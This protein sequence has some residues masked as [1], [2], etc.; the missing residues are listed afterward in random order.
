M[1]TPLLNQPL[2]EEDFLNP[3]LVKAI[4]YNNRSE[5]GYFYREI[6]PQMWSKELLAR[7]KK[8]IGIYVYKNKF[9]QTFTNLKS[10]QNELHF[11]LEQLRAIDNEY[12]IVGIHTDTDIP[13]INV[14]QDVAQA[15]KLLEGTPIAN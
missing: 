10:S 9:L 5:I 12:R 2:S 15:L 6:I 14:P 7:C 1:A 13:D 3:N 8:H 4:T 11:K